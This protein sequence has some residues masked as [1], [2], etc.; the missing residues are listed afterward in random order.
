MRIDLL[1]REYP[2]E[3]YGGAGAAAD[4]DIVNS[5][6]EVLAPFTA[7]LAERIAAML[8]DPTAARALGAAGRERAATRFSWSAVALRTTEVYRAVLAG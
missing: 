6:G 4:Q 2:P 8:E 3:V 7:A 1:T 5:A